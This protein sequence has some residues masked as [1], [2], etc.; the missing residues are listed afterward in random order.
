MP[1]LP[2]PIILV[3]AP[4][5]PAFSHRLR[6]HAQLLLWKR[7]SPMVHALSRPTR[8]RLNMIVILDRK[9]HPLHACQGQ[10]MRE[11]MC[12][13]IWKA[14]GEVSPPPTT[15]LTSR[16]DCCTAKLSH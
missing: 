15:T 16:G 11:G 4:Y 10:L 7:S 13:P 8:G 1:P 9:L 14:K 6:P 2:G 3:V 12:S 5:A